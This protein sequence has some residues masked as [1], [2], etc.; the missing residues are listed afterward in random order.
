MLKHEKRSA[1][2]KDLDKQLGKVWRQIDQTYFFQASSLNLSLPKALD[3]IGLAEIYLAE[4][5]LITSERDDGA[6][7]DI[8]SMVS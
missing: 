7:D 2:V 6:N 4:R 5:R 8:A 1:K 3:A